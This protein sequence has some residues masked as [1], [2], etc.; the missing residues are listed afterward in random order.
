M[1][2]DNDFLI[3]L[4]IYMMI[5]IGIALFYL[6]TLSRDVPELVKVQ[7][8]FGALWVLVFIL[9]LAYK[10]YKDRIKSRI[11]FFTLLPP[12][13]KT[14]VLLTLAVSLIVAHLYFTIF[15]AKPFSFSSLFALDRPAITILGGIFSL[16]IF[17][18]ITPKLEE[19]FKS[20]LS[21]TLSE[22]LYRGGFSAAMAI[23]ISVL[24]TAVFFCAG[25][26][27]LGMQISTDY[28]I[29]AFVF[30]AIG[31]ILSFYFRSYL[32][33]LNIH[34]Y[35]SS[36]KIAAIFGLPFHIM[37]L[38]LVILNAPILYYVFMMKK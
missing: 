21:P 10:S 5:A 1:A 33:S 31:T 30:S 14:K 35:N 8:V 16:A 24:I 11:G 6:G 15:Q 19:I 25:H 2:R 23:T 28:L 38:P 32:P 3:N 20:F 22:N 13:D 27:Y 36:V 12:G 26:V 4:E 34:C 37:I 17:A 7:Q 9:L 18:V 29:S